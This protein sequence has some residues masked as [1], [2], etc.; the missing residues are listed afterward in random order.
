M[1]PTK[2]NGLLVQEKKRNIDFKTADLS[3]FYRFLSVSH[4]D[5]SYQISSPFLWVQEKKRKTDFQDGN[6]A[7]Y[8]FRIGTNLAIFDLQVTLQLPTKSSQWAFCFRRR[9]EK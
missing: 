8:G 6:T 4:P 9:S 7:K 3:D 2:S 5:A 1:L